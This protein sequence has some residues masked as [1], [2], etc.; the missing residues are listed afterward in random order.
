MT[1]N[2]IK[3]LELKNEP[4]YHIDVASD[5]MS[6]GWIHEISL[7]VT[8]TEKLN[9]L[10]KLNNWY[11]HFKKQIAK[12]DLKTNYSSDVFNT[13]KHFHPF[14]KNEYL[15]YRP[16][17]TLEERIPITKKTTITEEITMKD[18]Y[19]LNEKNKLF[20]NYIIETK[21]TEQDIYK[22]KGQVTNNEQYLRKIR[23]DFEINNKLT[24][25]VFLYLR[26]LIKGLNEEEINILFETNKRERRDIHN[27]LKK[28]E[29]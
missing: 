20:Q 25:G 15:L 7:L 12:Q 16:L 14:S 24:G 1:S 11:D 19:F 5:K 22:S 18:R 29:K 17:I 9:T 10:K 6:H 26:D 21:N 23:I 28:I 13:I 3:L 27:Q 2:L 4:L 8:P